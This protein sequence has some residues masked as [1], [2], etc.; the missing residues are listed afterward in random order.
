MCFTAHSFLISG[1]DAQPVRS[2][3]LEPG[4]VCNKSP[5]TPQIF[6]ACH[7]FQELT[8]NIFLSLLFLMLIMVSSFIRFFCFF[9]GFSHCSCGSTG[10]IFSW[11]VRLWILITCFWDAK[12]KFRNIFPKRP[13]DFSN[14]QAPLTHITYRTYQHV[15]NS[16]SKGLHSSLIS[17]ANTRYRRS[18]K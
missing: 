12:L 17:K 11:L 6:R 13:F 7:S 4:R 10:A 15:N 2:S 1:R 5:E 3:R 14:S 18:R 8:K 9:L 16:I